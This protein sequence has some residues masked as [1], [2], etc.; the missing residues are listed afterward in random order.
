M[1]HM[2]KIS[3]SSI[4]SSSKSYFLPHHGILRE[5]HLTTKLRTVF[6]GSCPSST[7]WSLNDLQYVGPKLQNDIVN[8]LLRFRTY[9]YAVSADISKMYRCILLH[10]EHRQYQQILWRDNS[11]DDLSTY[12]LNTVSYGTSSAPYLAIRCIT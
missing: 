3:T 11:E 4:K 5:N 6:D 8:I 1:S 2:T 10:P 12:Q 9:V 7:G